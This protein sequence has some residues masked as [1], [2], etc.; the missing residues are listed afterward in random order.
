MSENGQSKPKLHDFDKD[1]GLEIL[2]DANQAHSFQ[3]TLP[4]LLEKSIH[5]GSFSNRSL[6]YKVINEEYQEC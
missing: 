4:T 3:S 6:T 5:V 1:L 2:S